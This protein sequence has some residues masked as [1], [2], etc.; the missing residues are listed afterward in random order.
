MSH[1]SID[2]DRLSKFL[3]FESVDDLEKWLVNINIPYLQINWSEGKLLITNDTIRSV[4]R[5]IKK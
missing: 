1:E 2:F 3:E 5:M 4:K